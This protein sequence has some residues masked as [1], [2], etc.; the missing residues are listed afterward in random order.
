MAPTSIAELVD[1]E[2]GVVSR[3]IFVNDDIHQRELE[4]VFTRSWLFIGHETQIPRPGDYFVSRMGTESVILTRDMQGGIHVLLNTCRHR[5]MKVCR[6]DLGNTRVFTCPYHGWV[7]SV[8]GRVVDVP[9]ALVGVPHYE[10]AYHNA[11]DKSQWGLIHVAQMTN[12]KG[13]IWATWDPQAPSFEQAMG[14]MRLWLDALLD[15]RDGRPGGSE[16]LLGVQ[17]W[18]IKANW[19]FAAENFAGDFHHGAPTHRSV[20]AVGIGFSDAQ[21]QDRH[22]VR[23]GE[24]IVGENAPTRPGVVSFPDL[25]H[26]ARGGYAAGDEAAPDSTDPEIKAYFQHVAAERRRRFGDEPHARGN[27]G[28][29][30]PNMSFHCQAPRTILVS[31][32]LGPAETEEWRWYL[33]DRDA[34]ESVKDLLRHYYLRYSGPSGMTEQDDMENWSYASEASSGVVARRYPYN[35][36]MGLG[37]ARAVEGLRG[38]VDSGYW[39]SEE[40]ARTFLR[41]WSLL[42][43]TEPPVT[44]GCSADGGVGA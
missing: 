22:G 17:K 2:R 37:Y 25:G 43:N 28:N 9:G 4:R 3:E 30:F 39:I 29:V 32:P 26:A 18:R 16:V 31:H 35:Y 7:Y 33:V 24:S 8:D 14:D 23:R 12:Y 34:P 27:G 40:N 13:S 42:M 20:E 6:Y 1:L 11:L 19:K 41:R 5:G 36:Q 15:C 10:D 21:T 38:A 44:L